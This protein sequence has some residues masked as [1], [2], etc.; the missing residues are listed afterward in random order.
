MANNKKSGKITIANVIEKV[1]KPTLIIAHNKTLAAQLY[2]EFKE[3]REIV[4]A[5]SRIKPNNKHYNVDRLLACELGAV[6]EQKGK[7]LYIDSWLNV[8]NSQSAMYFMKYH[9]KRITVSEE[10][11]IPRIQA[12]YKEGLPL[13]VIVYG[14]TEL[15]VMQ[16]CIINTNTVD[17]KELHC[18]MCKHHDYQI[19]DRKKEVYD[20]LCD[21]DCF[22]HILHCRSVV[23][24]DKLKALKD[25]GISYFRL[26]FT[27]ESYEETLHVLQGYVDDK[28]LNIEYGYLGYLGKE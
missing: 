26:N 24:Y 12:M 13:E 1:Q 8:T 17:T 6:H 18:N 4:L 28:P 9:P 22:N 15:M 25:I 19:M 21:K 16:H 10:L 5:S 23:A 27:N 11:T 20:I 2:N 14:K 3:Y 7:E